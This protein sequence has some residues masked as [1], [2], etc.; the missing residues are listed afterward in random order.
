MEETSNLDF[1]N[2]FMLKDSFKLRPL[3]LKIEL[4]FKKCN[5]MGKGFQ[6]EER[7]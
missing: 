3:S 1:L 5:R 2:C 7:E 4:Y 6:E